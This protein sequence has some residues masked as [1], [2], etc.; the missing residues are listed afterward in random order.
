M[1]K[2]KTL[3]APITTTVI[4]AKCSDMFSARAFNAAGGDEGEYTGY[5][6]AFM[7]GEHCGDYVELTIDVNTGR[8]VNWRKPSQVAMREV[9]GTVG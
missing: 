4:C 9:F 7:P 6:P 5:V 2:P 1:S 3:K 8:I